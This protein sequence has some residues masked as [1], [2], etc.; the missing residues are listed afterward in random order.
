LRDVFGRYSKA[1]GKAKGK[2]GNI[3]F[4]VTLAFETFDVVPLSP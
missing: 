2:G 4:M 3:M 1:K